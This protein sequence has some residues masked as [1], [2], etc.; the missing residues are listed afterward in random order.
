MNSDMPAAKPVW[1][2]KVNCYQTKRGEPAAH[3]QH[4]AEDANPVA[5][6]GRKAIW[7]MGP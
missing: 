7:A 2:K 1:V 3:G 6:Q 4:E 5:D